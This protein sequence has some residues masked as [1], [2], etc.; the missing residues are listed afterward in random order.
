M[1]IEFI[2]IA[3]SSYLV[4]SIP[5]S[6]L[7]GCWARGIDIRQYGTGVS[8][9]S[10]LGR[11]VSKKFGIP[12][13]IWDFL[14]GALMP[15]VAG[16]F[17]Q[18][19]VLWPPGPAAAQMAVAGIAVICGHNWPVFLRFNG[20]RG[21]AA[22]MGASF[23]LFPWG[24]AVFAVLTPSLYFVKSTPLPLL[25][26]MVLLPIVSAAIGWPLAVTIGLVI[27]LLILVT[28]RL[29]APLSP[30]AASIHKRQLLINRLLFDRD[31]KDAR[32]WLYRKPET[33]AS[34]RK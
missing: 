34:C 11:T 5:V 28:R 27:I 13:G 30:E 19:G 3:I 21:A 18:D 29:T 16:Y 33:N 7:V 9:A 12:V 20:G 6:Y 32:L 2:I 31:I 1:T 26:A 4:G 22:T 17:L 25:V 24:M 14:K 15:A 23:Y 10:N 8:G